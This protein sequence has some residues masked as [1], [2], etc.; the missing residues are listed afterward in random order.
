M[1][2][3]DVINIIL[4]LN[5]NGEI[6]SFSLAEAGQI[7]TLF[8]RKIIP[9]SYGRDDTK[10]SKCAKLKKIEVF[11][12]SFSDPKVTIKEE[13]QPF[14]NSIEEPAE[15]SSSITVT[16]KEEDLTIENEADDSEGNNYRD[17]TSSP[18][19]NK[20]VKRR[21]NL[22]GT[23]DKMPCDTCSKT[24]ANRHALKR[25]KQNCPRTKPLICK[26]CGKSDFDPQRITSF[27]NH[28]R[29]CTGAPKGDPIC[30]V[31]KKKFNSWYYVEEHKNVVHLGIRPY[32]CETCGEKYK[33]KKSFEKHRLKHTDDP[34]PYRCELCKKKFPSKPPLR[35]HILLEHFEDYPG[36]RYCLQCNP[37]RKFL[38][39]NKLK[40]HEAQMHSDA[41]IT[42]CPD[43]GKTLKSNTLKTHQYRFHTPP[44]LKKRL[45]CNVPTCNFVTTIKANLEKHKFVHLDNSQKSH[46]CQYCRKGFS[47]R[48][49]LSRHELTHTGLRQFQCEYCQKAFT[50]K[51]TLS[52]HLRLHTGKLKLLICW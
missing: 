21:K 19:A 5:S 16:I 10:C 42:S 39:E 35:E 1:A 26:K 51:S 29:A 38:W 3:E 22:S 52:V 31:C 7:N 37:P 9:L 32:C 17:D 40:S 14:S 33:T 2:Q 28:E 49:N 4:D 34:R 50:T 25:H 47:D 45:A 12:N 41:F 44:E 6:H 43:C 13:P 23:S 18:E 46:R 30:D 11:I 36:T 8:M 15:V 20:V 27:V 24:Y 48:H